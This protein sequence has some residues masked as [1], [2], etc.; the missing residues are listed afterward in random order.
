MQVV[1]SGP[2]CY[3]A[4][5]MN[6]GRFGAV[7]YRSFVPPP[8]L[9]KSQQSGPTMDEE[10]LLMGMLTSKLVPGTP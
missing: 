2:L 7:H 3:L 9:R 6:T 4:W 8:S 1:T 5:G 10:A